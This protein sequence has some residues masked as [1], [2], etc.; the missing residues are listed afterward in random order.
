[1]DEDSLCTIYINP[2]NPS[3]VI[4]VFLKNELLFSGYLHLC[5]DK[6]LHFKCDN[7]EECVP[8][9][10]KPSV[11]IQ[12]ARIVNKVIKDWEPAKVLIGT[13]DENKPELISNLVLPN[14][15]NLCSS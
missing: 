3:L 8:I 7:Y 5:K 6:H 10:R 4:T 2:K 15:W 14:C 11:K 13:G 12:A 1:M 9:S